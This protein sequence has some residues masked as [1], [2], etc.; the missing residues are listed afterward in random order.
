MNFSI[1]RDSSG[2]IFDFKTIKIKTKSGLF[3][4]GTHVDA[5]WH[6]RPYGS[7]T[8]AHA[9]PM[10]HILFIFIINIWAI[11]HISIL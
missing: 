6:S 4:R 7:A 3:L 2:F 8:R 9:A 1:F 11:V 5:T 10:R